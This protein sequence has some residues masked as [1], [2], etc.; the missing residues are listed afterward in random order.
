MVNIKARRVESLMDDRAPGVYKPYTR[1]GKGVQTVGDPIAGIN[2]WCPCGVE[3]I[4]SI[5]FKEVTGTGWNWD[6]DVDSPTVTPSVRIRRGAE[7][8]HGHL[9]AGE[10]VPC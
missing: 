8:W 5:K 9:T 4:A 3:H 2:F 6:R 1:M 7:C 10:W